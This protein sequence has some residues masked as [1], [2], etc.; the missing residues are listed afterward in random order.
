MQGFIRPRGASWEL[1]V[2]LGTDPVTGRQRYANRSVRG[3]R[4]RAERVLKEMI[5]A[6][7]AGATHQAGATFGE[8]AETWL[9]HARAH[10][11]PNTVVETRRIL[12]RHL[13]PFLGGVPLAALR[14]E[15]LDDLYASC[16]SPSTR[17]SP[18]GSGRPHW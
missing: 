17:S 1:R 2:Y 8:L 3:P 11:A 4:H 18:R 15:H 6:A 9:R 13:L 5:A 10:L 14:P 16:P 12:D 7:Q